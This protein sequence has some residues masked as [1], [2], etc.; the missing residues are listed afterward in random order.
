[1]ILTTMILTMAIM[2]TAPQLFITNFIHTFVFVLIFKVLV[3][4]LGTKGGFSFSVKVPGTV[5]EIVEFLREALV[6]FDTM[7]TL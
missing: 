1:M 2:S 5:L 3:P 6:T 4:G 7:K